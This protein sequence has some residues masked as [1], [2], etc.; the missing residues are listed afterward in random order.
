IRL[1]H[2][3][4]LGRADLGKDLRTGV[5]DHG[6]PPPVGR[7]VRHDC[8]PKRLGG[9]AGA[10]VPPPL[11]LLPSLHGTIF[12]LISVY[13]KS[14]LLSQRRHPMQ[15]S[16]EAL[17]AL[18]DFCGMR[19]RDVVQYLG[20]SKGLVSQWRSGRRE[21][22]LKEYSTLLVSTHERWFAAMQ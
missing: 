13:I 5:R 2:G 16:T 11:F 15:L 1:Q 12:F 8:T 9:R 3:P 21:M 20:V 10:I 19:Q 18:L 4:L 17:F 6:L 22:G 14:K 7:L